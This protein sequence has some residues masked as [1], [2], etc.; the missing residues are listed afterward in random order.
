MS[1]T[2]IT[3]TMMIMMMAA[4]APATGPAIGGDPEVSDGIT[5]VLDGTAIDEWGDGEDV[6]VVADGVNL[7]VFDGVINDAVLEDDWEK[8]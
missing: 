6:S 2:V 1:I 7:I 5:D 8:L 4:M 3:M